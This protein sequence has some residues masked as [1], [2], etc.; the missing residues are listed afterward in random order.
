M[1]LL[2]FIVDLTRFSENE[3][4]FDEKVKFEAGQ[5]LKQLLNFWQKSQ[6]EG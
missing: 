6:A 2:S 4:F 3:V 1:Q 5:L